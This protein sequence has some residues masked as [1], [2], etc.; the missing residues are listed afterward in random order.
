MNC[1][2]HAE[3]G[4]GMAGAD[5]V[6]IG[7]GEKFDEGLEGWGEVDG[8]EMRE[9]DVELG[10]QRRTMPMMVLWQDDDGHAAAAVPGWACPGM[11][12]REFDGQRRQSTVAGGLRSQT[13]FR[14]Q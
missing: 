5:G 1:K 13:P 12:E 11:G 4:K 14:S 9:L 2:Y 7:L 6:V 10:G 8:D 3:R